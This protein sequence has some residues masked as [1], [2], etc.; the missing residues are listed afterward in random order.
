[1]KMIKLTK[2]GHARAA[3][4]SSLFSSLALS[5]SVM[6]LDEDQ[7]LSKE[8]ILSSLERGEIKPLSSIDENIIIRIN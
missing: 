5:Y 4:F 2:R 1:M 8:L 3:D 6:W 7:A